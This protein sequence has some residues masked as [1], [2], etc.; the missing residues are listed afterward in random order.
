MFFNKKRSKK[1]EI[2]YLIELEKKQVV[3]DE[4]LLRRINLNSAVIEKQ[5][6]EIEDLNSKLD[7]L[8]EFISKR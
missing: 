6:Q 8:F 5:S 3:V 4:E 1:D 2:D 7:E